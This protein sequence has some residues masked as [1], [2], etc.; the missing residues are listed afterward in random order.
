MARPHREPGNF[1]NAAGPGCH[2]AHPPPSLSPG[3][4][5]E[6]KKKKKKK[7]GNDDDDDNDTY[8]SSSW[9]LEWETVDPN[10]YSNDESDNEESDDNEHASDEGQT[11]NNHHNNNNDND[12]HSNHRVPDLALDPT[13]RTLTLCNLRNVFVVAYITIY[14]S[15]LR[16]RN[17]H[18]L[19]P[20][21]TTLTTTTATTTTTDE[22]E[23][24]DDQMNRNSP[25]KRRNGTRVCTTL[26]VRCPP[27]TF[28]HL[29]TIERAAVDH[30]NHHDNNNND[31]D[32]DDDDDD[33]WWM[34]QSFN[35]D[36]DVQEW[37]QHENPR[38]THPQTLRFPLWCG[39]DD[40]A[41]NASTGAGTGNAGGSHDHH[42]MTMTTDQTTD[43][44]TST[45]TTT[46][47]VAAEQSP[48][49]T[50]FLCTQ[51]EGGALT[52]F[53]AGNY[54][55]IDWACPVGT[56]LVAV[57]NGTIVQVKDNLQHVSGI[58]VSNL[59]QW[60]AILLQV[61]VTTATTTTTT[62]TTTIRGDDQSN[63]IMRDG[64]L[65][66]EYVHIS[67][68]LVQVGDRVQAGQI[69]GRSGSIGFSP[70]PHLHLC[71]YRSADPTAATVR[72]V[73]HTSNSSSNN[74][75][76]FLPR[77]GQWYNAQG[78]VEDPI[79]DPDVYDALQHRKPD[80]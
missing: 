21:C 68:S 80:V 63:Y 72:V 39:G 27:C 54:H 6:Q 30:H 8:S 75:T 20:G 45:A 5:K 22:T 14:D 53:F 29:C 1:V 15:L 35:I 43:C 61:D 9:V 36:S 79:A 38:D 71:A 49:P 65:F 28:A 67:Q 3:W 74:N 41:G 50:S 10:D 56:P 59:F 77:A 11:N 37:K 18:I 7:N 78:R 51:G 33:D 26:I 48:Y 34:Q 76:T 60:N 4:S 19:T 57:A 16:G 69:I 66:V 73:F 52:H 64:P 70:E 32:D 23:Q 2:I 42:T 62:T 55:A 17:R 40:G 31:D 47:A 46:T 25:S 12:N 58:A 44:T 13:T 24:D